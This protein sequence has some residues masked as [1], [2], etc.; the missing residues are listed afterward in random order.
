MSVS[1]PGGPHPRTGVRGKAAAAAYGAIRFGAP[2]NVHLNT[3]EEFNKLYGKAYKD[4][5]EIPNFINELELIFKNLESKVEFKASQSDFIKYIKITKELENRYK[6]N[7][8]TIPVEYFTEPGRSKKGG[9]AAA[10]VVNQRLVSDVASAFILLFLGDDENES[11]KWSEISTLNDTEL[12]TLWASKQSERGPPPPP[13]SATGKD[14]AEPLGGGDVAGGSAAAAAAAAA[15]GHGV[16]DP[17]SPDT[18]ETEDDFVDAPAAEAPIT[19]VGPGRD[20]QAIGTA[21]KCVDFYKSL[22]VC[23]L[24][25]R[26]IIDDEFKTL[27]PLANLGRKLFDK[28]HDTP[29]ASELS[30]EFAVYD[31][32]RSE[33]LEGKQYDK[34][35][36]FMVNKMASIIK[37]STKFTDYING[38][39][40]VKDKGTTNDDALQY[41][42]ETMWK[43][44]PKHALCLKAWQVFGMHN[45]DT[46]LLPTEV[47]YQN[48][49]WDQF[50]EYGQSSLHEIER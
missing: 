10:P 32:F 43:S 24:I 44:S 1:F 40:A 42:R 4:V 17:S 22:E 46:R 11:K 33:I 23:C 27:F 34:N 29:E 7:S 37:E 30:E 15:A 26:F 28:E 20:Q 13:F 12:K 6:I 5:S 19:H 3:K 16:T 21:E 18:Q 50:K 9:A 45:M 25:N 47:E 36:Q 31:K 39:P 49:H 41:W 48:W 38:S 14:P 8:N 2:L 35:L